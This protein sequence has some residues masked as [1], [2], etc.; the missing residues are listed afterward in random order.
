[1]SE[2]DEEQV[3]PKSVVAITLLQT[4]Q[5]CCPEKIEEN[6]EFIAYARSDVPRLIA[7]VRRLNAELEK[8]KGGGM[9]EN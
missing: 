4:P 6:S 1:M 3:D 2:V 9:D 7:E 5:F 8:L